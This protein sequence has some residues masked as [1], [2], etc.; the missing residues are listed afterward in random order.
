[1]I[2]IILTPIETGA[3]PVTSMWNVD[4]VLKALM[5]A[6]TKL[7]SEFGVASAKDKPIIRRLTTRLANERFRRMNPGAEV[8]DSPDV[9]MIHLAILH[10]ED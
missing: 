5:L 6:E 2:Q 9:A 8:I 7:W 1:M 4:N 3:S 10:H